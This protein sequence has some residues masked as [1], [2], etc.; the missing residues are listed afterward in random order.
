MLTKE[1]KM[2]F[3]D[4]VDHSSTRSKL[5]TLIS[6]ESEMIGVMKHEEALHS[7]FKTSKVLEIV[8]SH[9]TLWENLAFL[10]NCMVNLTIIASYSGYTYSNEHNHY[11]T[12]DLNGIVNYNT[13]QLE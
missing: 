6:D 7:L 2:E 3:H 12:P 8:A 11:T 13:T 5:S 10:S 4:N 1:T 9:K